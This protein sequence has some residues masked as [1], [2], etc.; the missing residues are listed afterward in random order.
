MS[1]G[2]LFYNSK[3]TLKVRKMQPDAIGKE[4]TL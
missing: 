3:S 1:C 4:P 2:L